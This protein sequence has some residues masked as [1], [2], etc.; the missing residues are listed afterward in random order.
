M[1]KAK[2]PVDEKMFGFNWKGHG[3]RYSDKLIL[4]VIWR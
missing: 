3:L 4:K 1:L 2:P